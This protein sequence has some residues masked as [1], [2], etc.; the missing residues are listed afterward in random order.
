MFHK[1]KTGSTFFLYK[2]FI[3]V[4]I[5]KVL[6]IAK[7]CSLPLLILL[8]NLCVTPVFPETPYSFIRR[9]HYF[10]KKIDVQ[11]FSL[12]MYLL[13]QKS[14]FINLIMYTK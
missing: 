8:H 6:K 13:I 14:Y 7:Q 9:I 5:I 2:S 12:Y 11:D 4:K 10:P 3:I 1:I